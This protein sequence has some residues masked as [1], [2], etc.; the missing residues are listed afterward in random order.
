MSAKNGQNYQK[1][2]WKKTL[3][4]FIDKVSYVMSK[5]TL[6]KAMEF[7][8]VEKLFHSDSQWFTT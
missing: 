8:T 5:R 4:F 2:H 6:K 7:R 1:S 3:F